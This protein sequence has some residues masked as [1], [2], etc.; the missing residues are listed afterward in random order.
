M[1]SDQSQ[2]VSEGAYAIQAGGSVTVGMSKADVQ[3][4]MQEVLKRAI[5]YSAEADAK[6]VARIAELKEELLQC[7]A[8]GRADS[9]A[10]K[11]PDFQHTLREAHNAYARSGDSVVREN[12]VDIISRRS[13]C[14]QGTL[15]ALALNDAATRAA[16]LTSSEFAALTVIYLIRYTINPRVVTFEAFGG[17]LRSQLLPF[18]NFLPQGNASFWHMSSQ[19]VGSQE[20][21]EVSFR[22]NLMSKYGGVL[23]KGL[24][25]E[26]V[27]Q[28]NK[29]K[30]HLLLHI[31]TQSQRDK[32]CIRPNAMNKDKFIENFKGKYVAGEVMRGSLSEAELTIIWNDYEATIPQGDDFRSLLEDACQG[33]GVLMDRW[34]NTSLKSFS[35]NSAGIA[36]AHANAVRVV[37]FDAPLSVWI[38]S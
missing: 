12:L 2:N 1:T 29:G 37:N 9:E 24:P 31:M 19:S 8:D 18:I 22:A 36:I 38:N 14:G 28:K 32:N 25:K 11:E 10:I 3:A 16:N 26:V 23:G 34:E 7:F 4:V 33:M 27:Y 30:E 5:E 13:K 15:E 35:L 17:Y 21:G 20:I 6:A